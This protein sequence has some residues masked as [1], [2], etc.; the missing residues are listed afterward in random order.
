MLVKEVMK[1]PFVIDEDMSLR[2]AAGIMSDKEVGCL[3]YVN[4]GALE[5][6]ITDKDLLRHYG[7]KKK[8][9]EVMSRNVVT[10][11]PE[12]HVENALELMKAEKIKRLPVVYMG[13]LVGIVSLTDIACALGDLGDDFFF[14]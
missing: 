8:V 14:E 7:V 3:I 9:T 6:I 11:N 12:D 5:G 2:D 1:A 10:V 4:N 13:E